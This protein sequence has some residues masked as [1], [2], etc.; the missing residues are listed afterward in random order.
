M[1]KIILLC[2]MTILL[3]ACSNKNI[4]TLNCVGDSVLI[5][6]GSVNLTLVSKDDVTQSYE[7][8]EWYSYESL[9]IKSEEEAD[10]FI[11]T[12]KGLFTVFNKTKEIITVNKKDEGITL[13]LYLDDLDKP[14]KDEVM[15]IQELM[16]SLNSIDLDH[17][18]KVQEE[19]GA[20]CT[21]K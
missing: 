11:D 7:T 8:V 16:G 17:V 3:V 15:M 2:A 13:R 4:K 21:V 19:L 18:Q 12:F 1:K 9:S 14:E 5:E 10:E 6:G 20:V